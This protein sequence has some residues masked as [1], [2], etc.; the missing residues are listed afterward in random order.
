MIKTAGIGA[1]QREAAISLSA[2]RVSDSS[3]ENVPLE[4]ALATITA[5][6]PL[7]DDQTATRS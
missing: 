2:R 1:Q 6:R 4:Q 7:T 5:A 3:I